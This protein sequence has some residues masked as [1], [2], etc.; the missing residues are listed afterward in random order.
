MSELPWLGMASKPNRR[1]TAGSVRFRPV[2]IVLNNDNHPEPDG[3]AG[4]PAVGFWSRPLSSLVKHNV[5]AKDGSSKPL[6]FYELWL[7]ELWIKVPVYIGPHTWY[8]MG[9]VQ[10]VYC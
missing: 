6:T 3:T 8:I 5:A 1:L 2:P 9:Y 10:I 4:Q 7:L